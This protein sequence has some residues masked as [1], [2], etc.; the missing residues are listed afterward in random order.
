MRRGRESESVEGGLGENLDARCT[1]GIANRNG[2]SGA[3][4]RGG[5][6]VAG[7]LRER[8]AAKEQEQR[9]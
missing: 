1:V 7:E 8:I 9:I 5:L 2:E 3:V 4:G 6:F